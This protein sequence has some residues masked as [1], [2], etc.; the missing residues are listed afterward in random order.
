VIDDISHQLYGRRFQHSPPMP[1]WYG[2]RRTLNG[3]LP[4]KL[5]LKLLET[6]PET[7]SELP[8]S[9]QGL[10]ST[11][12]SMVPHMEFPAATN[13]ANGIGGSVPNCENFSLHQAGSMNVALGCQFGV[14]VSHTASNVETFI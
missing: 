12:A 11:P 14:A 8:C 5:D 4:P 7:H 1:K 6:T 10:C 13:L 2:S 9:Q 3:F